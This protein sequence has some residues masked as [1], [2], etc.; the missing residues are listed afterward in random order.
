MSSWPHAPSK[1]V[2]NPGTYIITAGTLN[3]EHF[4]SS[5]SKLDLLQKHIFESAEAQGWELQAWAIFPNHY[6]LVGFSPNSQDTVRK[7]TSRIHTLSARDLNLADRQPGRGVWYR[8][9]D[10]RITFEK[11]YLARLA[12]VHQNAVHHQIV[13]NPQE[14][15]WCSARWF[16][17][18]AVEPFYR[19]VMEFKVDRVN[20]VEP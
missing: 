10:T 3:K 17:L 4:F 14:Y 13:R 19:S 2:T 20:V 6:H 11:S 18:N 8:S 5:D 1:C 7:L 12:Y 15:R 9:W 16:F